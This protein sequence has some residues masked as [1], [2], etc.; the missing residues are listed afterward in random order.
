MFDIVAYSDIFVTY[1]TRSY[2]VLKKGRP[3]VLE[4]RYFININ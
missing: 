1:V 3:H 2:V 4:Q